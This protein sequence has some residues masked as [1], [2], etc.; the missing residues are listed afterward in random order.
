MGVDW[1]DCGVVGELLG[2]KTF[3]N[4]F[5]AYAD[6][7]VY[8]KNANENNGGET[9]S[10]SHISFLTDPSNLI[11]CRQTTTSSINKWTCF[12]IGTFS[13][14][15]YLCSVWFLKFLINW[16]SNWWIGSSGSKQKI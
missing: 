16:N 4:E 7:S 2:I 9:I 6:L 5:I 1:E 8:I 13:N 3:A 11:N 10:A 15:C 12:C 14:Y